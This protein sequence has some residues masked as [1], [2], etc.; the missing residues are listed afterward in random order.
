MY[1]VIVIGMG[2]A[3]MNAAL[4]LKR[5]NLNILIIEKNMPGG[6]VATTNKIENYLGY[7]SIS[8]PDLAFKMFEHINNLK[9]PYKIE[10][11]RAI[12][13]KENY[14]EV[15]TS[16]EIY[17]TK[18]IIICIGRQRK[19]FGFPNEKEL[20]GKGISYC[21]L[22][23]APLFKGKDVIVLGGN[24][25]AY[26]EGLFLS[27]ICKNVTLIDKDGSSEV[28]EEL[29]EKVKT[30]ENLNIINGKISK[31]ILVKDGIVNGIL[32]E[33]GST[34]NAEGIF[35]YSGFSAGAGYLENLGIL[36]ESGFIKVDESM[37]TNVPQI[38]AAGDIIKKELYQIT[39]AC[40][41]GAIAAIS[42]KKEIK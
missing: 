31:E 7:E 36:D 9:I 2:P 40:A 32:L 35:I 42:A 34:I 25:S 39:T 19:A 5:S 13:L 20:I 33:D 28:E 21:A 14:K 17:N 24:N 15:V 3:G 12:N 27:D 10:E 23:D 6:V 8:G 16:K 4:Y 29:K 37:R 38:Y 1:D 18:S 11:V 30:R 26:E 41:E 22:C